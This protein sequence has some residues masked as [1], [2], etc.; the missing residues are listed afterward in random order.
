MNSSN[1]I[2]QEKMLGQERRNRTIL[3]LR[4]CGG[5]RELAA[6]PWKSIPVVLLCVVFVF[7]WN[8][9]DTLN[10]PFINSIPLLSTVC[11]YMI[12]V[13][14]PLVFL[15]LLAGLLFLLGTPARARAVENSLLEIGFYS[16][17]GNAPVLI[18]CQRV[19]NTDVSVM[20]FYSLGVGMERWEKQGA[21]VQD[22]LNVHFVEKL[23]YGGRNGRNRNI[24]VITAAHG[25]ESARKGKLYDDD[26]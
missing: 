15:L 21:E 16:H 1:V 17:Y 19:K 10:A 18:S 23:K 8:I 6:R 24:I 26:F 25:A 12:A 20:A 22:A 2:R 13:F 7:L 5:I 14:I 9:R 11:G 3:W 4:L